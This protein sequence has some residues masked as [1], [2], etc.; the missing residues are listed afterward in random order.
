MGRVIQMKMKH[1]LWKVISI[2]RDVDFDP[3]LIE[4]MPYTRILKICWEQRTGRPW[5]EERASGT[6]DGGKP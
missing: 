4:G 1:P 2:G 3:A 6:F 5:R